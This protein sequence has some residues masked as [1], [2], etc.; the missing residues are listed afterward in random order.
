MAM[1][2][3]SVKPSSAMPGCLQLCVTPFVL[4][5]MPACLAECQIPGQAY[6]YWLVLAD[7]LHCQ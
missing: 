7:L 4:L 2:I 1:Y 3:A 5:S 6:I